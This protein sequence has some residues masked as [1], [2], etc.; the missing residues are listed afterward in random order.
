M[1]LADLG[2]EVIKVENPKGGDDSRHWGP[3]D[4]GGESAYYLCANRNKKSIAIDLATLQGQELVRALAACSD[5]VVENYKL[6]TLERFGLDYAALAALTRPSSTARS[7]VTVAPRR[8]P[9]VRAMISSSRPRA[10]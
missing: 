9:P 3:P 5:V 1:I 2:A 6:G 10:G 4:I 7:P 8:L